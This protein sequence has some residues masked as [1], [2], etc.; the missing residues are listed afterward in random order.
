MSIFV[1]QNCLRLAPSK[2]GGERFLVVVVDDVVGAVF[3]V[4]VVV[5][6]ASDAN[7]VV[8]KLSIT[9]EV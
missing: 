4:V 2:V 9:N 3:V 6:V 1:V 5:V 8:P 7:V